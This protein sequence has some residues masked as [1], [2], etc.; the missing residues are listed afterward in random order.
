M[1]AVIQ[2]VKSAAVRVDGEV[3]GAIRDGLAVLIGVGVD[4]T[5]EDLDYILGKIPHL[6]IFEDEAGKMNLSLTDINASV[7]AVSQFT[8]YADT[9][10]GRR[11]G[12]AMAA[13]PDK[14][15]SYY[16]AF[17]TGLRDR[18]IHVET[19]VFQARME[20][21]LINDGPVTIILDSGAR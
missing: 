15:E 1:R 3:T 9:R 4:D 16:E 17:V 6:R 18:G 12:F 8:L 10:K 14:A 19:G 2:R 13:A 5:S 20:V 11:P 7:L 21:E